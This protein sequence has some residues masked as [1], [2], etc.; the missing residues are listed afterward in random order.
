[1][2]ARS[3]EPVLLAGEE[4][5]VCSLQHTPL[6]PIRAGERLCPGRG[7]INLL[8]CLLISV[9]QSIMRR[10]ELCPSYPLRASHLL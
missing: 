9:S 8:S 1:M 6:P 2:F 3:S 5:A 10:F 7:L 4:E